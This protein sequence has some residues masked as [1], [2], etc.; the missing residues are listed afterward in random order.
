MQKHA[1]GFGIGPIE[2][3]IT[4]RPS[5]GVAVQDGLWILG[6]AGGVI[7]DGGLVAAG[8]FRFETG[9]RLLHRLL[10]ARPSGALTA[11]EQVARY[12][13]TGAAQVGDEI[14]GCWFGEDTA[15][16]VGMR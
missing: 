5:V 3:G 8:L 15:R 7:A 9:R 4:M 11:G 14:G 6:R 10:Q 12:G 2:A 16:A 13:R 1:V